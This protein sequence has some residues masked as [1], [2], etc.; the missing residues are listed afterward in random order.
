MFRSHPQVDEELREPD[1]MRL[2]F[3]KDHSGCCVENEMES[4]MMGR[5]RPDGHFPVKQLVTVMSGFQEKLKGW[6][7][8]GL[9]IY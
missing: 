8:P 1:M 3:Q 2:V 4:P 5:G 6:T 9:V 7:W